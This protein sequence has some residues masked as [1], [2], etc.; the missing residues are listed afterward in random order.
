VAA[1]IAGSVVAVD[2]LGDAK[3]VSVV[4][5]RLEA[6]ASPMRKTSRMAG[7]GHEYNGDNPVDP[8]LMS[9]GEHR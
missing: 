9:A 1:E 3:R 7:Q 8:A 5:D 6:I 4:L 2:A